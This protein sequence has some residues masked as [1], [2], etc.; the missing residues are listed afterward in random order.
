MVV[1]SLPPLRL[2]IEVVRHGVESTSLLKKSLKPS[3]PGE[4]DLI[5]AF[6]HTYH[7][8]T[9]RLGVLGAVH[10]RTPRNSNSLVTESFI[11]SFAQIAGT[12][13]VPKSGTANVT[14]P[15]TAA[16][17]IALLVSVCLRLRLIC[18]KP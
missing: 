14:G 11:L 18:V 3:V 13:V 9:F 12:V 10:R 1:S 16:M 17:S 4:A 6:R 5:K 2:A 8:S 7:G 15:G